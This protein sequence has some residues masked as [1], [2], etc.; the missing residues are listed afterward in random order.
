MP[1]R[2]AA[3]ATFP[4]NA[5]SEPSTITHLLPGSAQ[6]ECLFLPSA[7]AEDDYLK[8]SV[9]CPGDAEHPVTQPDIQTA[10]QRSRS[11]SPGRYQ[12]RIIG[13]WHWLR[14]QRSVR[15]TQHAAE[16]ARRS[17]GEMQSPC[18]ARMPVLVSLAP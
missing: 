14:F 18:P 15:N 4:G 17:G 6:C 9:R 13:A 10:G 2:W 11:A 16:A 7:A 5:V 8:W 1:S 12:L 3:P